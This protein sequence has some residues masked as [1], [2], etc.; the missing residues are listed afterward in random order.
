MAVAY[1]S[2]G[3]CPAGKVSPT[4]V[5]KDIILMHTSLTLKLVDVTTLACAVCCLYC[6]VVRRTNVAGERNAEHS[7]PATATR[8]IEIGT[9][10]GKSVKMEYALPELATWLLFLLRTPDLTYTWRPESFRRFNPEPG[11]N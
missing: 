5:H 4:Q 2:V 9:S 11:K 10:I 8:H 7:R 6:Y 1:S 3:Q